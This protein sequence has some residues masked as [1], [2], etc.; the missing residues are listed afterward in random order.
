MILVSNNKYRFTMFA[1][2]NFRDFEG[3]IEEFIELINLCMKELN[4]QKDKQNIQRLIRYYIQE[5]VLPPANRKGRDFSYNYEHLLKFIYLRKQLNDGWPL[6]KI[7]D[8]AQYQNISFFEQFFDNKNESLNLIDEFKSFS[9]S[10]PMMPEPDQFSPMNSSEQR[11]IPELKT[12]LEDINSDIGNV[13]KQ[14]FITLQLST[15]IVL[16]IESAMMS[17]M[18]YDLAKKIGNAISSALFHKNPITINELQ[19]IFN[20]YRKGVLDADLKSKEEEIKILTKEM[21]ENIQSLKSELIDKQ[22]RHDYESASF[23]AEISELKHRLFETNKELSFMK[24]KYS[25]DASSN[26]MKHV[27][28]K[29]G[30]NF[31]NIMRDQCPKCG[32]KLKDFN[33]DKVKELGD[34]IINKFLQL[35]NFNRESEYFEEYKNWANDLVNDL[36]KTFNFNDN[37]LDKEK[38][39]EIEL[40]LIPKFNRHIE[41]IENSYS[42]QTRNFNRFE[43]AQRSLQGQLEK[44]LE[45]VRKS[46][47]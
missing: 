39:K 41:R 7:R 2:T 19:T 40:N 5:K 1:I 44:I 9:Q 27:C 13:V 30:S 24:M 47:Q 22:T 34:D 6:S 38:A 37:N 32:F 11:G 35:K 26:P 36:A 15:S 43:I 31:G 42:K 10:S 18:N 14:N 3:N 21:N 8:T 33:L 28:P 45:Q 29:C 4:I 20:N 12:A 46:D 23:N 16:L 25:K 17:K